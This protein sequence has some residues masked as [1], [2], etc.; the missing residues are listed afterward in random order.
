[1]YRKLEDYQSK[2]P[3]SK[4]S[5]VGVAFQPSASTSKIKA[6]A[7]KYVAKMEE[8]IAKG[9][10]DDMTGHLVVKPTSLH[11]RADDVKERAIDLGFAILKE[12]GSFS[13]RFSQAFDCD[14]MMILDEGTRLALAEI[15]LS[16]LEP[17][18]VI[19]YGSE[20]SVSSIG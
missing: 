13:P 11:A 10:V 14:G 4:S 8:K 16:G 9:V 19:D 3:A 1:M 7:V 12:F 15:I 18:V 2:A 6:A 5:S 17:Q 20:N